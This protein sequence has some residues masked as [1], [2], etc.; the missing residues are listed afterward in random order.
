MS[1]QNLV[2]KINSRAR[3]LEDRQRERVGEQRFGM[4]FWLSMGVLALYVIWW[5]L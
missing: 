2:R 3:M 5:K 4:V 1:N